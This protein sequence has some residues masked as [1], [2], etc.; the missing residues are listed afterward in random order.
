MSGP[1]LL[2]VNRLGVR[3]PTPNGELSAV[4]D[5]SLEVF[6]GR[7]TAIVGE[8]ASGK[9]VLSRAILRLLPR[10]AIISSESS[11]AF[12][13]QELL[14]MSPRDLQKVRGRRIAM[15]F[16]DPMTSLNP[17]RTIGAQLVEGM[18]LHLG[19]DGASASRRALDLLTRVG[20]S[21]PDKRLKQFPHQLSGGMRQRVVIAMAIACEPELLIAD[22]PTTA[23]D[24]TVQAEILD[25]LRQLQQ[26]RRMAMILITHDLGVAAGHS[27]DI[28]VM[29]AGQIVEKQ[30]TLKLFREP[31]MPYTR[32][33]LGAIPGL[34][35]V[36]HM[37]LKTIP[38]RPPTVYGT[39]RGCRFAPRCDQRRSRCEH[40]APVLAEDSAAN[41][42]RCWYPMKGAA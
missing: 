12:D 14:R 10:K 7:T 18:V 39:G 5:V 3:F 31:R 29:Y 34:R 42:L 35:D 17:V 25:L 30:S 22:E 26:E 15:V 13:G 38:G 6:A 33:L 36:P 4:E 23:L 19:L 37:R 27:D 11:I 21:S 16:Q 9:S 1:P 28:V 8:S 20:I 41:L 32:A 40:D 24:V 2:S